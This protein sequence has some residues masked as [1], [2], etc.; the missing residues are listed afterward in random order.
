MI[1][2]PNCCDYG[3]WFITLR[4]SDYCL[5]SVE[6]FKHIKPSWII[7]GS[8]LEDYSEIYRDD[9]IWNLI[10]NPKI[11]SCP[12]CGKTLPSLR[13]KD[14]LP[15]NIFCSDGDYCTTCG[16]RCHGCQCAKPEEMWE[17][18]DA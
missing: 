14:E 1:I 6:D 5:D 12:S 18:I 16:E 4:Y 7:R 2:H 11:N 10:S 9:D 3:K 8:K 17:I 13:L 15:L